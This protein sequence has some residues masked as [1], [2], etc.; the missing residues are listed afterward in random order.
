MPCRS[1]TARGRPRA[2]EEWS[3]SV[4]PPALR[5]G[6]RVVG[7]WS[8]RRDGHVVAS[9]RRFVIHVRNGG[10][11]WANAAWVRFPGDHRCREGT[12]AAAIVQPSDRVYRALPGRSI[13]VGREPGVASDGEVT[14]AVRIDRY[15]ATNGMP[16]CRAIPRRSQFRSPGRS[17]SAALS[18][19]PVS[20]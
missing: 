16:H 14:V 7:H 1:V 13:L 19:H 17:M 4:D 15:S 8:E 11:R 6:G 9:M 12:N 5:E 2:P 3:G 10:T 20:G 18:G